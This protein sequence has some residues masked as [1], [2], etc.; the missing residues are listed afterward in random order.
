VRLIT[1]GALAAVAGAVPLSEFGEEP[2]KEHLEDLRWLEAAA[3][4]HHEVIDAFSRSGEVV[5]LQFATV[6]RDDAAVRAVLRD[7]AGDFAAAFARTRD[8]TEWGVKAYFDPGAPAEAPAAEHAD[9]R[10]PE[11]GGDPASVRPGTAY[12]LR[13][14][15][16]RDS[17]EDAY[18]R[19][20]ER[21][22]GIRRA[23]ADHAVAGVAHPPQ[24]P[25]L[26]GYEGWMILN[27]SFL[28]ERSGA[29][30]FAEAVAACER[31]HPGVRL[32]L[33]GPWPPYSFVGFAG[34]REEATRRED[35]P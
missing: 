5:P 28:V 11:D 34:D 17:K 16:Q 30:A 20:Q 21:A 25:R 14:R 7:R 15:A 2:L 4:A 8:R 23:L 18:R 22:E 31:R 1:E 12:L 19:A 10:R 6:Y 24:D 13:R 9:T 27:D 35:G 26:A 33:S 29:G 32:E 3:R